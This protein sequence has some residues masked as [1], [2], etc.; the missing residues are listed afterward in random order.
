MSSGI[1]KD[2][3]R[4]F[5]MVNDSVESVKRSSKLMKLDDGRGSSLSRVGLNVPNANG[6]VL[7]HA[8]PAKPVHKSEEVQHSEKQISQVMSSLV[9]TIPGY[10][11]YFHS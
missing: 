7:P 5:Q 10:F 1:N 3:D 4:S 6:S 9:I 8:L 2:A 11:S